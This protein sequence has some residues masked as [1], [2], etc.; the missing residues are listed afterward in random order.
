[1]SFANL[2]DSSTITLE[3]S[4]ISPI[5]KVEPGGRLA[6]LMRTRA[7]PDFTSVTLSLI[8]ATR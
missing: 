6:R 8:R 4:P 7:Q 2:S 5:D 1:M 3:T